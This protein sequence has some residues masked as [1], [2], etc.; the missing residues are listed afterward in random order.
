MG[1]RHD[2]PVQVG[3]L[4]G[5][6]VGGEPFGLPVQVTPQAPGQARQ[7]AFCVLEHSALVTFAQVFALGFGEQDAVDG[8]FPV[9][10]VWAHVVRRAAE[11]TTWSTTSGRNSSIRS[12][13]REGR[14]SCSACGRPM[15]GSRPAAQSADTA[16]LRMIA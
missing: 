11:I 1:Q 4:A 13:A 10:V 16:S 15:A 12:R 5:I 8:L 2:R 9:A 14:R 7:C 3:V 6:K